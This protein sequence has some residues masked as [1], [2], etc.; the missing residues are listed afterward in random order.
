MESEPL[1]PENDVP[2]DILADWL[3]AAE[4]EQPPD[5]HAFLALHPEHATALKPY[6]DEWRQFENVAGQLSG[7][8]KTRLR[9][10][11]SLAVGRTVGSLPTNPASNVALTLLLP[12]LA[13]Y[14][15]KGELGRG[16]MGIV[17]KARQ[18]SLDRS[19]AL[20]VLRAAGVGSPAEAERFRNEAVL[21]AQL[22]HPHIVPIYEV[23]EQNGSLYYSMK[24]IEGG[25]LRDHLERF[26]DAPRAT[27]RLVVTVARAIQ[28]AHQYGI[29]HRDLKPS[30]ILLDGDDHP[31]VADFGLA[32]RLEKDSELTQS[33]DLL[34]TPSYMAPNRR[35]ESCHRP[36]SLPTSMAWGACSMLC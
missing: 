8:F 36:R 20:K 15:L 33:G 34:G 9:N 35:Q 32:K 26:Q 18:K 25:S 29:L 30:N 3:E 22:D 21:V 11:T 7:L 24:L 16:G 6:L 14:E 27:G 10:T 23:G 5:P 2:E 1:A 4:S 13:D 12:L 28:H 17:Y 19:V 31:H